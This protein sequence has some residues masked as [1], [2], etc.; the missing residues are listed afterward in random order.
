MAKEPDAVVAEFRLWFV[1]KKTELPPPPPSS[2]GR[3]VASGSTSLSAFMKE[4]AE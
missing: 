1:P 4:N 2:K 3:C